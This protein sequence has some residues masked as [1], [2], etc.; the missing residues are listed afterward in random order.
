MKKTSLGSLA[1]IAVA[2][3]VA[4]SSG[5][6]AGAEEQQSFSVTV[7]EKSLLQKGEQAATARS[8]AV[9]AS[10]RKHLA[11][12][13]SLSRFGGFASGV[14]DWEEKFAQGTDSLGRSDGSMARMRAL[15]HK[16][17]MDEA[18]LSK[19]LADSY[20]KLQRELINETAQ[21]CDSGGVT[22]QD[23]LKNLQ[24]WEV[25]Q[26]AWAS[27]FEY[28]P[29]RAAAMSK[30]DW[31]R[32]LLEFASTDIAADVVEETAR[33]VGMWNHKEGSWG[34][35]LAKFTTQLVLEAV[36]AEVTDPVGDV[37]KRLQADFEKC[38]K[39]VI[40]GKYGFRDACVA[41]TQHHIEIRRE[42]LGR[43]GKAVEK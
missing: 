13:G 29:R 22:R 28:V 15:F 4:C 19:R 6:R 14:I 12:V 40:D 36:V 9:V 26:G 20:M 16:H 11:S 17:I 27:V 41:L 38:S 39:V 30:E 21:V 24:A 7:A 18:D 1:G 35:A 2:A 8:N 43:A 31:F 23:L 34:D 37:A 33:G 25:K 32:E 5:G 3:F 10:E 42:L